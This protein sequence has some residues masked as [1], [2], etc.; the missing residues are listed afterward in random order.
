MRA[1]HKQAAHAPTTSDTPKQH[2]L[3]LNW[4]DPWH[5]EG[6]GSEI[7]L[8]QVTKRLAAE[9]RRVTFFTSRYE[10]STARETV[11]GVHYVRA[12]RNLT[13]YLWAAWNLLTGRFGHVDQVLEVQNGM[14]FCSTLFTRARVSVLVHHVHREQWPVV[15]RVLA[16]VGWFMESRTGPFVNRHNQ[17]IAVSQVT[18]DEL[19]T[20]GVAA[21]RIRIAYNGVPPVPEFTPQPRDPQP[22][23]VA[24]SRLVPHKQV[25][26]AVYA[27]H[28]LAEEIPDATLTVMGDGW[29]ADELA[30]LVSRLGLQDRVRLLGFVDDRTKFE[31][32][33]RAWIHVMPSLKEGWGL[34]IIEAAHVSVPSIAYASAG[35]VTES[36][37]DGVTGLLAQDQDDFTDCVRRLLADDELRTSMG[38]K[39]QL[40]SEQFS[41]EAT[42]SVVSRCLDGAPIRP[43]VAVSH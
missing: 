12:G 34:S 4:R 37:L 5:P 32:L 42:T 11:D 21:E 13:V 25:E 35:G 33:S 19:S 1:R 22:S 38:D 28:D 17:Y 27:L 10:G 29:W 8:E 7:Y 6:G 18:A 16:K 24:L 31:E 23:L 26:H 3:V 39:A 20:L 43:A 41:W 36:I 9:D 40:R 15:G 2:V 14:P 30:A